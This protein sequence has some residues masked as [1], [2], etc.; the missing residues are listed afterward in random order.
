M[1]GDRSSR[2]NGP[3]G[4]G[5]GGSEKKDYQDREDRH[6]PGEDPGRVGDPKDVDRPTLT[7][8]T[9]ESVPRELPPC[10]RLSRGI[11]TTVVS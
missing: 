8:K 5:E 11:E 4:K 7:G 3:R 6:P 9:V 10:H 1:R 2:G